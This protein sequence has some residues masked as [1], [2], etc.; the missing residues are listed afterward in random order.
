MCVHWLLAVKLYL[1]KNY[2]ASFGPNIIDKKAND[3]TRHLVGLY[4]ICAYIVAQQ[5]S[6]W[7]FVF[8]KLGTQAQG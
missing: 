4:N 2:S 8:A 3:R 1:S 6:S 7:K 5:T